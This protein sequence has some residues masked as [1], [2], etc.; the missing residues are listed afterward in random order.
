MNFK[1]WVL[2]YY[3]PGTILIDT[4]MSGFSKVL[5]SNIVFDYS[6]MIE[7]HN[8]S[9]VASASSISPNIRPVISTTSDSWSVELYD[10]QEKEMR[11]EVYNVQGQLVYSNSKMNS[12]HRIPN[13]QFQQGIY[14]LKLSKGHESTS[15]KLIRS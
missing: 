1:N 6:S 4:P 10:N 8:C 5:C 3:T 9:L 15:V 14:I 7:D 11:C 13:S 12:N 2:L